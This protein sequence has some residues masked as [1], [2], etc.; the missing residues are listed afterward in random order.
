MTVM[1]LLVVS[2]GFH[3]IGP[4]TVLF[5]QNRPEGGPLTVNWSYGTLI[6]FQGL[7]RT[8]P[9]EVWPLFVGD[10]ST[11]KIN[12][13]TYNGNLSLP[14]IDPKISPNGSHIA[15]QPIGGVGVV[16]LG[17]FKNSSVDK[18]ENTDVSGEGLAWS[19]DSNKLAILDMAKLL[20]QQIGAVLYIY[21]T[22]EK[23]SK[24]IV[25]ITDK[26]LYRVN[27]ISWSHDGNK[28]AFSL[29]YYAD[30]Y[31]RQR[32]IFIFNLVENRLIRVTSTANTD[33]GYVTWYPKDDILVFAFTP[34]GGGELGDTKLVFS[35]N[36]GACRKE[37]PELKGII[38]PS[39]SPD[40]KQMVFISIAGV[41][42]IDVAK[43]IHSEFLS[44]Q[45]LCQAS[46]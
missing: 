30:N 10:I 12:A 3:D 35:T 5:T 23:R 19:P 36:D 8:Y 20:N 28:I 38:S 15:F 39:W 29:E 21:D 13:L 32:D 37:F 22:L 18:L 31:P 11:N 1:C 4:K 17:L 6:T 45:K 42:L 25:E 9:G 2:C 16:Q 14:V 40:G 41:E 46:E 26:N 33:E 43:V 27:S 34:K 44:P 7:G 24:K